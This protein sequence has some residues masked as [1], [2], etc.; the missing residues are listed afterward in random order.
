MSELHSWELSYP[1]ALRG[2]RIDEGTLPAGLDLVA[3]EA[4]TAYEDRTAFTLVLPTGESASLSFA[5]V[6]VLSH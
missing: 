5:R 3:S 1:P 2:Y 4:R 6:D